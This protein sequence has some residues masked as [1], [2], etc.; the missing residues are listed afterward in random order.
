[1]KDLRCSGC[2]KKLAEGDFQGRV[3]IVCPRCGKFNAFDSKKQ[4]NSHKLTQLTKS[5]V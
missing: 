1:M 5:V 3:E 2:N 4:Y